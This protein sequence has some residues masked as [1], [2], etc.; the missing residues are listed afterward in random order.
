MKVGLTDQLVL[1]TSMILTSNKKNG[2]N[3]N[4]ANLVKK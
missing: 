1:K 4:Q 3:N 2:S